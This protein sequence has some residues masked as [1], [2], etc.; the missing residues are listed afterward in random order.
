MKKSLVLILSL[1]MLFSSVS[2][3]MA[4]AAAEG[5]AEEAAA[6]DLFEVWNDDGESAT[7]LCNAVPASGGVLLA[8]VSVLKVPV[9]QL[10]VSDGQYAWEVK[11][12]IPDEQEDI[13]LLFCDTSS[14]RSGLG[15][16]P[17]LPWGE[18]RPDH[19]CTV[20][21]G[22]RMGSR[23][24]RGVV[25]AEE[26]MRQGQRYLLLTLTDPAP[27]GSPVLT[28][29]GLL[30]GIVTAQ[31]A[32]GGNRVLVLP[33]EGIA[34]GVTG[35]VSLLANLPAWRETP[36]GLV[37]TADKNT[38][39]VDWSAMTLP[40]KT[41]G[42]EI[43]MV[44]IDTENN[45][46]NCYPAEKGERKVSLVLTPG[47]VYI[48]GPVVSAGNPDAPPAEFASVWV[49]KAGRV[50]DNGFT[51]VLTAI[52]EAPA[53]GLKEGELP[54]PVTEVTEALLRSGRACF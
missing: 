19:E 3:V 39:T 26:L 9:E 5:A 54:T 12:A 43:Y 50:T 1:V 15:A 47:R 2:S 18:S 40:E 53:V 42:K 45:Y 41:A 20:L 17:L 33:S 28:A 44:V 49:P 13:V 46:L 29:D 6:A 32:E 21:F 51:P 16:W 8:P 24:I 34:E 31:W 52:A 30:A 38:V 37:V 36:R 27:A 4:E 10:A 23:I 25:E 22:D 11:A 48:A 14:V 35:V 7:W